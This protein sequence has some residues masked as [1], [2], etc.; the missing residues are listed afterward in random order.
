MTAP[1]GGRR[2]LA[3]RYVLGA[4]AVVALVI[5]IG[6]RGQPGPPLDPRSTSP[7]G[8]RGIVEVMQ[9]LG[10]DMR[11]GDGAPAAGQ[12]GVALVIVDNL[13]EDQRG[14]LREW[15]A[16]GGRLVLADPFSEL[17]PDLVGLT[18]IAF[19]EPTIEPACEDPLVAGVERVAVSG[20]NVFDL[21]EGAT[22]CFPR[23][24]GW[25][26]IRSPEGEGE[27][28]NLGGPLSLTNEL[29]DD[30]DTAILLVNLLTPPEGGGLHV[31]IAYDPSAAPD[32]LGDILPDQVGLAL[33]Q[34]PLAWV[35]LV[36]WR[37]RRHGHP[38]V[39]AVPVRIE[40][41]ETTVAVGNLLHRAGR[42]QD[43][44]A[45]I[46]ARVHAELIRRLGIPEEADPATFIAVVAARTDLQPHVLRRLLLDPLP[47]SDADLVRYANTAATV[48]AGIRQRRRADPI[49]GSTAPAPV[50][51]P[52]AQHPPDPYPGSAAGPDRSINP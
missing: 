12:D 48:L 43:A 7:L 24:D 40:A 33:L 41:A 14:D 30:A 10:T 34:I 51:A 42:A 21:P 36:W 9:R 4:A 50:A 18:S 47:Q 1:P 8:A 29:L 44:A 2:R 20:G 38:P 45:I 22:G 17:A 11:V 5:A 23:N 16:Q 28:I 37:A 15:V 52:A 25:W 39:E 26:M 35:A 49:D 3:V 6:P 19:T 46:R 32:T 13:S 27:V 31:V